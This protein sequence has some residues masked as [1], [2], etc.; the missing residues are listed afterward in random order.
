MCVCS[1]NFG[2]AFVEVLVSDSSYPDQC[3]TLLPV[4]MLMTSVESRSG[5]NKNK[6]AIYCKDKFS[7]TATRR[8]WNRV[9]IRCVQ[10]YN[11]ESQF[12]LRAV[13][14]FAESHDPDSIVTGRAIT[15]PMPHRPV[16]TTPP[17]SVL[18]SKPKQELSQS[19]HPRHSSSL[20]LTPKSSRS[21]GATPK[22]EGRLK[23]TPSRLNGA[24]NEDSV[25]DYE[26][27]GVERQSRL[28][29]SCMQQKP[30]DSDGMIKGSNQILD[31][32]SAEKEKY[33]DVLSPLCSQKKLLKRELPKAEVMKD[34]VKSYKDRKVTTELAG[35]CRKM[36]SHGRYCY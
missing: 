4:S 35:A 16:M 27:S 22:Q 12:G 24:K 17:S 25:K 7:A 34:F 29:N 10:K 6:V 32:I 19:K 20:S 14:F 33:R 1:G 3:V 30:D 9:S 8:K 11:R 28:F 5:R 13:S 26:F 18:V 36:S 31:R 2:S 23:W 21:D 15:S